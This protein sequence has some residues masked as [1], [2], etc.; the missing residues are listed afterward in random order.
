MGVAFAQMVSD[1]MHQVGL[2][3]ANAPVKEEGVI[4]FS[5][6]VSY[7]PGSCSCQLIVGPNHESFECITVVK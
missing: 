7:S 2:S 3:K 1:S 5:G 4:G 6:L